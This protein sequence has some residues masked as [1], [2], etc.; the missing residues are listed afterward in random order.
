[1][2]K[3][4]D[5]VRVIGPRAAANGIDPEYLLVFE[6]ARRRPFRQRMRSAF[7]WTY[8]AVLDDAR[9]RAFNSTEDYRQAATGRRST[10]TRVRSRSRP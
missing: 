9:Y 10:L 6:A 1:M 5:V 2:V 8:K 7:I 3:R 4:S